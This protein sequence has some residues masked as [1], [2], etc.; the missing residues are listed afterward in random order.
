MTEA[1]ADPMSERVQSEPEPEAKERPLIS[2][3]FFPGLK[4]NS[5]NCVCV[6]RW[7]WGWEGWHSDPKPVMKEKSLKVKATQSCPTACDPMNCS[8][9][10]PS[11]HGIL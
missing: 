1:D 6:W 11:V 2:R 10:G 9:P 7:W 3:V 8:L 4:N 5:S